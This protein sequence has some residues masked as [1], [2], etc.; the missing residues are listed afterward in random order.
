MTSSVYTYKNTKDVFDTMYVLSPNAEES[1][2][3]NPLVFSSLNS[4][5]GNSATEWVHTHTKGQPKPT[6]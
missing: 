2:L 5:S 6:N 1:E 3:Q 4:I